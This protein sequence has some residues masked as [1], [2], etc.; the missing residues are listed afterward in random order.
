MAWLLVA[1]G[2]IL[3]LFAAASGFAVFKVTNVQ[4]MPVV[5]WMAKGGKVTRAKLAALGTVLT[6]GSL[7]IA[8]IVLG[9]LDL[10]EKI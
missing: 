6:T 2:V 1:D 7:G 8:S 10:V 9:I 5:G 3:V 4:Q